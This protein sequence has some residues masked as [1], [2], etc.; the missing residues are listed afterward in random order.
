MVKYIYFLKNT[1]DK[2][3]IFIK[4]IILF[5]I[6]ALFG[7]VLSGCGQNV[8]EH[9]DINIDNI[10]LKPDELSFKVSRLNQ[11][12]SIETVTLLEGD[13]I[14]YYLYED[15]DPNR[16]TFTNLKRNTLY[17]IEVKYK[18][19]NVEIFSTSLKTVETIRPSIKIDVFNIGSQ[20]FEFRI[21]ITDNTT[22]GKVE[23]IEILVDRFLI[24]QFETKIEIF[25]IDF[26]S[27]LNEYTITGKY[28]GLKSE[29]SYILKITYEYDLFDGRGIRTTNES[30]KFKTS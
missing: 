15:F 16:I 17:I 10:V 26:D 21:I 30:M 4:K 23:S 9:K 28:S 5:F 14:I 8:D 24:N 27:I 6:I 7:L 22:S 18:N 2:G 1:S 29:E 19:I 20:S 3:V 12:I 11:S 25:D 13:K